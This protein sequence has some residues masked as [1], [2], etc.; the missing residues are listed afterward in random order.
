MA[1]P[2]SKTERYFTDILSNWS[3][4]D[5]TTILPANWAPCDPYGTEL[6]TFYDLQT[7]GVSVTTT[8]PTAWPKHF[9]EDLRKLSGV[10]RGQ[11]AQAVQILVE[12]A[13]QRAIIKG[14]FA[15]A[16]ITSADVKSV[17][18]RWKVAETAVKEEVDNKTFVGGSEGGLPEEKKEDG[19]VAVPSGGGWSMALPILDS[20]RQQSGRS[21]AEDAQYHEREL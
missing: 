6:L 5:P 19:G 2:Q 1:A 14:E 12:T 13:Q 18:E 17:L 10:T 4:T 20:V 15:V 21:G 11:H 9:A 7:P 3:L 16:Q 8:H